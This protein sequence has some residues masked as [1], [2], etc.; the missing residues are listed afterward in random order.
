MEAAR[1]ARQ[2]RDSVAFRT[3]M[4]KARQVMQSGQSIRTQ[5]TAEIRNVLTAEQRVKFDARQQKMAERRAQA[6][7]NGG[8]GWG[9]RGGRRGAPAGPRA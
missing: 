4:E 3:N 8:K 7:K 1:T 2:N 6:E 5:E 9:K